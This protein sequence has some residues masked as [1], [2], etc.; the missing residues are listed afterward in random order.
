M[1]E[2]LKQNIY[3]SDLYRW[4][5]HTTA[6]FIKEGNR[7]SILVLHNAANPFEWYPPA[8]TTTSIGYYGRFAHTHDEIHWTTISPN[9]QGFFQHCVDMRLRQRWDCD[10]P[11]AS[12]K[13]FHRAYWLAANM[14]PLKGLLNRCTVHEKPHDAVEEG[15]EDGGFEVGVGDL[16]CSWVDG[17]PSAEECEEAWQC[18][19]DDIEGKDMAAL[20][21]DHVAVGGSERRYLT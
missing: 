3:T 20:E 19:L 5:A 18:I 11:K 16:Q 7:F 10:M 2:W 9:I 1:E 13:R 17:Q 12:E 21:S 14:Q 6:G 15:E 4:H 8:E